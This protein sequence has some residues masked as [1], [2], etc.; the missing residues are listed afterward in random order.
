MTEKPDKPQ[1]LQLAESC[2][3]F[4]NREYLFVGVG[5]EIKGGADTEWKNITIDS[6]DKDGMACDDGFLTVSRVMSW[7]KK[8][9]INNKNFTEIGFNSN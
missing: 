2:N 6:V 3:F 1:S 7:K 5:V 4:V 9:Y 8:I